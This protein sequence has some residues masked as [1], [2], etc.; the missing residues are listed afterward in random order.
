MAILH[1]QSNYR[2][3]FVVA[4]GL[5]CT[6]ALAIGLTIW[7]LRSDAIADASKDSSNLAIVLADQTENSIQSIDLVLTEIKNYEELLGTKTPDDF[8]RVLRSEDTYRFLMERLSRLQQADSISLVDKDGKLVN[9]TQQWPSPGINL[10]DRKH[11]QHF[12]SKDDKDIYISDAQVNRINGTQGITFSKRING[13]NNTFLGVVAV[14][15]RLTYFQQ[16][17]KSIASLPD[18]MFT[19]LHRDHAEEC[20]VGAV[21]AFTE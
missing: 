11:F 15:V 20:I 2:R 9:T 21:D 3:L 19:L 1:G 7:W 8:D 14:A 12:K 17:Y 6:A 18:Q 4:I 16:I 5:T 10:S 13:A